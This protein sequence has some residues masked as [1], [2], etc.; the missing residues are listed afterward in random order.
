MYGSCLCNEYIKELAAFID[1]MKKDM[2]DN[3]RGNLCCHCKNCNKEN[4]YH[5]YD[6]FEVTFDQALIYGGLSMLE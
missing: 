4:K 2:F 1:F 3:V 5:T 6:V